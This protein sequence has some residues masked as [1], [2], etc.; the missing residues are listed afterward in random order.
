MAM[1]LLLLGLIIVGGVVAVRLKGP[2]RTSILR[3]YAIG[4]VLSLSGCFGA[5]RALGAETSGRPWL[6][7][8]VN[9]YLWVGIFLFGVFVTFA[10][11]IRALRARR[12]E[13]RP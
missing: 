3:G 7:D 13:H 2:V 4:V 6:F 5:L 8:E 9:P 10:Q 12:E 1:S 11:A